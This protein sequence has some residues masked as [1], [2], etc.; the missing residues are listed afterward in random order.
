MGKDSSSSSSPSTKKA[1]KKHKKG[2][3]A[4]KKAKKM[5]KRAGKKHKRVNKKGSKHKLDSSSSS[6]SESSPKAKKGK[7]RNEGSK[8]QAR[9]IWIF[10]RE[11]AIRKAEP[12]LP[13]DEALRKA[14][15]EYCQIYDI[16]L[17]DPSAKEAAEVAKQTADE[18]LPEVEITDES[19][20]DAV[21]V[22]VREATD[23]ARAAGMV[24]A[25][26]RKE[27][28][29]ALRAVL[30]AAEQSGL[31]FSV[32]GAHKVMGKWTVISVKEKMSMFLTEKEKQLDEY[33]RLGAPTT[34]DR[35]RG[36]RDAKSSQGPLDVT[37]LRLFPAGH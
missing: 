30:Q 29:D 2:K 11:K 4:D 5:D 20:R 23:Q 7:K 28:E 17:G 10:N 35:P 21:A 26:V 18:T 9:D 27:A 22:A 14:V 12:D 15:E 32:K 19:V 37:R 24:G 3:L 25:E 31:I 33:V 6:L 8:E 13:K 34:D 1:K 36:Q 16:G